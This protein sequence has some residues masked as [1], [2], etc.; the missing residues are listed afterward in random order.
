MLD[1]L[2]VASPQACH[3]CHR[4]IMP[5]SSNELADL[6]PPSDSSDFQSS[7]MSNQ[8]W[9]TDNIATASEQPLQAMLVTQITSYPFSTSKCHHQYSSSVTSVSVCSPSSKWS[10]TFMSPDWNNL[11]EALKAGGAKYFNLDQLLLSFAKCP[12]HN[13]GPFVAKQTT[14]GL[15][16]LFTMEM[17]V[18][19][20]LVIQW[21]MK[22]ASSWHSH[23]MSSMS[24]QGAKFLSQ[25]IKV[26]SLI[27]VSITNTEYL[28]RVCL[29]I[30]WSPD[31][32]SPI[33]LLCSF[34]PL[35]TIDI[36]LLVMWVKARCSLETVMWRWK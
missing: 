34:G 27:I 33:C 11:R 30:D 7:Q 36:E 20:S 35:L 18:H 1:S 16:N 6:D 13:I 32:D 28:C 15:W 21:W 9:T 4:N 2:A 10:I 22:F 12:N 19:M 3:L 25:I 8:I 17:L 31:S 24:K 14:A 23:S 26:G 5:I 29:F